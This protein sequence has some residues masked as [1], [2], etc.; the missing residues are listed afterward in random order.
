[1]GNGKHAGKI[2]LIK[3]CSNIVHRGWWFEV[4]L[5]VPFRW[6]S[7]Q[8]FFPRVSK[9]GS[10]RSSANPATEN[11][12]P[13]RRPSRIS[14]RLSWLVKHLGRERSIENGICAFGIPAHVFPESMG[15]KLEKKKSVVAGFP[16]PSP[17]KGNHLALL[18]VA[19]SLWFVKF[20]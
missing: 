4:Q 16:S 13:H 7:A 11:T 8:V 18:R 19:V 14:L 20:H 12:T 2:A 6:L 9:L 5:C 3:A 15:R 17:G 1:M 10:R